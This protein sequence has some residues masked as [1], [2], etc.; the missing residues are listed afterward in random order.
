MR[1][2]TITILLLQA[3]LAFA[4]C[5]ETTPLNSTPRD[6]V[7]PPFTAL[8]VEG[9]TVHCLNRSYDLAGI[10]PSPTIGPMAILRNATV[11]LNGKALAPPAPEWTVRSPGAV[12]ARRDW[13]VDHWAVRVEQLVEYDGFITVDLTLAPQDG[14]RTVDGLSVELAFQPDASTL[15]QVPAWRPTR[16][17]LWPE[18][19]PF[20]VRAPGVWGGNDRLGMAAYVATFRDW[21]GPQPWLNLSRDGDGP[22]RMQLR[23]ISQPTTL[24]KPVTWRLGFIATPVIP[25]DPKHWQLYSVST[26][27]PEY[28]GLAPRSLIWSRMSDHY[29]TFSTN[30]PAGDAAHRKRVADLHEEGR[31]VLAYTTYAHI[32]EGV[33][34][35]PDEWCL[36]NAD[37]ERISRSVGSTHKDAKRLFCCPGSRDWIEWKIADLAAGLDR[38]GL[39]GFYVDTSYV[40]TSCCNGKH[41]HGWVD[42]EGVRHGDFL[43]WSM[44]EVWRRAYELVCERRGHAPIYAHH[45]SGCPPALA[46]FT[47]AFCDGEQYTGQSIK[48]LTP[49]AFRAQNAGRNMGPTGFLI[50]QYYRSALFGLREKGEHFGPEESAML[51]LLHDVLPTGHPGQHPI[52]ELIALRDDLGIA[53]AEW[54][55][56]Y[57]PANQ[58]RVEGAPELLCSC[59][60][61][62]RGDSLVVIGNTLY[63]SV[64][65][66]LV[67]PHKATAGRQVVQ[68][69]V[70]S[71]M[72]RS[73]PFTP[74]YRWEP[75]PELLEVPPRSFALVG[76]VAD[77]QKLAGFASQQGFFRVAPVPRRTP[78]PAGATLLAD[79]DDPD[80]VLVND[81]SRL[82]CTEDSPVDSRRALRVD[83]RPRHS[84][85]ALLL[86]FREPRDWSK[87][88]GV[89]LWIR[90]AR[91]YP[92]GAFELRLCNG[93]Q[94]TPAATLESPG[95]D[96]M[97]PA[98]EWM[99]LAYRFGDTRRDDVR[100]L[101]IY[102]HRDDKGSGAFDLDE[103][104]LHGTD[105]AAPAKAAFQ[106]VGTG[107][108]PIP[109]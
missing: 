6:T 27:T 82:H 79:S 92:V 75:A 18:K 28:E 102:Y 55:P 80:W 107:L 69:D 29:A 48:Q 32:E 61:T 13:Q 24:T 93:S 38:Y 95:E 8:R 96:T 36:M 67:G 25:P 12:L 54:N 9:S 101:R 78:I 40:I 22:G 10:V 77:P 73:A 62:K 45:K 87:S 60:R 5:P 1:G 20:E 86:H 85:A 41:G 42:E 26:S 71:R 99:R 19:Q 37:L 39:D 109:D 14:Q 43:V 83:P 3:T 100:I 94:Y 34:P 88:A 70:L 68:I 104:I 66:R 72:G 58:W 17:G 51:S 46:G 50:D 91:P 76:F 7:P 15:Y 16:A 2:R 33:R 23:I 21:R 84:S 105:I 98:G 89:T 90:P 106:G 52:R 57:A 31:E 56:H 74:G 108:A 4:Q 53:D 97:L 11:L 30:A 35:V 65:G 103:V 59:Y 47:A 81:E 44:R 64:E 49:D 63:R